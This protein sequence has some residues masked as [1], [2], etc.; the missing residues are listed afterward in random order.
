MTLI[1]SVGDPAHT[2]ELTELVGAI[3]L[4]VFTGGAL[5]PTNESVSQLFRAVDH[6]AREM[7]AE[8][9]LRRSRRL[10]CKLAVALRDGNTIFWTY[11]G[12]MGMLARFGQDNDT[13]YFGTF[14]P[15]YRSIAGEDAV[16]DDEAWSYRAPLGYLSEIEVELRNVPFRM[17]GDY[18][19]LTSFP[20]PMDAEGS[21]PLVKRLTRY[22]DPA[23]VARALAASHEPL[24]DDCTAG[25]L[26]RI[27]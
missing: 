3:A 15:R 4:D 11:A 12:A 10:S 6:A 14:E 21:V 20:L 9:Q 7:S 24:S 18:I 26:Y 19:A 22:K 16:D 27:R 17:A 23:H 13:Q 2:A 8:R 5:Q 1:E 25:V